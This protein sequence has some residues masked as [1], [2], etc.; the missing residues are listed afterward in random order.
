MPQWDVCGDKGTYFS[1]KHWG[2][3]WEEDAGAG[4]DEEVRRRAQPRQKPTTIMTNKD[5]RT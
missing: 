4:G 5:F 3:D 2:M 1:E